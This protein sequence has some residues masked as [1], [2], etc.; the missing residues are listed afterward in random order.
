MGKPLSDNLAKM[1]DDTPPVLVLGQEKLQRREKVEIKMT[2]HKEAFERHKK[3]VKILLVPPEMMEDDSLV[4]TYKFF[5]EYFGNVVACLQAVEEICDD[6]DIIKEADC[7]ALEE[8]RILVY[9]VLRKLEAVIQKVKGG[10]PP[11]TVNHK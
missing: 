10:T 7:E 8:G 4:I 3:A 2:L 5:C 6:P 1:V 9:E 11:S